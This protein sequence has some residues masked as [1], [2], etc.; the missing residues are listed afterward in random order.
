M[1]EHEI[2]EGDIVEI[3]YIDSLTEERVNEGKA[4][5]MWK[6][7]NH[8]PLI[9]KLDAK[10]TIWSGY[11]N[12]VRVIG[13]VDIERYMENAMALEHE[14]CIPKEAGE[15]E[16]AIKKLK[17]ILDE[18][19]EADDSVCYVTSDDADALK[20]AIKALEHEPCVPQEPKVDFD[21]LK[22]K[23]LSEVDG[24]TDDKWLRYGDVC[25]RIS[26]SI[27]EYAGECREKEDKTEQER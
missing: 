13:H 7:F 26:D 4:L 12:I 22:R 8:Q 25:D 15:R 3:D 1:K 19:T 20:Q 21:E 6:G 10:R 5:V 16:G 14:P 2:R 17:D 9:H 23:I 24:G 27:D 11:D 18:A